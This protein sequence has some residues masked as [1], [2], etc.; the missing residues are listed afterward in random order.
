MGARQKKNFEI[1][2]REAESRYGIVTLE[3]ILV[4]LARVH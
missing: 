1:N 4:E 3:C 2:D